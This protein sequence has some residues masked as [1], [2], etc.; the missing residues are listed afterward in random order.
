MDTDTGS[1]VRMGLGN[2]PAN[3]QAHTTLLS[4]V[5]EEIEQATAAGQGRL[6]EDNVSLFIRENMQW[7]SS[8]ATV[9]YTSQLVWSP[10]HW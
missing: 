8:G 2:R 5:M 3:E 6:G 7:R 4:N 10:L 1:L 9:R